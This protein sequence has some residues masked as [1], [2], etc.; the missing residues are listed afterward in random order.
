[1]SQPPFDP[2]DDDGNDDWTPHGGGGDVPLCWLSRVLPPPPSP[3]S[4]ISWIYPV[5]WRRAMPGAYRPR[6]EKGQ[7]RKSVK[8]FWQS[9]DWSCK[10]R[11]WGGGAERERKYSVAAGSWSR[12][13]VGERARCWKARAPA[14]LR[15]GMTRR[16]V[17]CTL[18]PCCALNYSSSNLPHLRMGLRT[19]FH[20]SA[21]PMYLFHCVNF[22]TS[23]VTQ[24]SPRMPT[25]PLNLAISKYHVKRLNKFMVKNIDR[26]EMWQWETTLKCDNL[27]CN[28]LLFFTHSNTKFHNFYKYALGLYYI[29]A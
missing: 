10:L 17:S 22:V 13:D 21:N 6:G 25:Y 1:M 5:V 28:L 12:A 27:V 16:V 7:G 19:H 20:G 11:Q 15:V 8:T 24:F 14:C 4:V 26:C 9:A 3:H 23:K 18:N 2:G 29:V